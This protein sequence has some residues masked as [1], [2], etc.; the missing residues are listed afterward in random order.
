MSMDRTPHADCVYGLCWAGL[1]LENFY[2]SLDLILKSTSLSSRAL[3]SVRSPQSWPSQTPLNVP[4][5]W[6]LAKHTV[7]AMT[8][9]GKASNAFSNLPARALIE[10]DDLMLIRKQIDFGYIGC[11]RM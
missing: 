2:I 1:R 8:I 10:H 11:A 7:A 5:L 9:T 4:P 6:Q 3:F